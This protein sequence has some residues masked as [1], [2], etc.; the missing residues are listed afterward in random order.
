MAQTPRH[1]EHRPEV[2]AALLRAHPI[3]TLVWSD[4]QGR[5]QAQHLPMCAEG[6]SAAG[7]LVLCARV[8]AEHPLAQVGEQEAM[9]IFQGRQNYVGPAQQAGT[10]RWNHLA[11]HARGRLCVH[12]EPA[13]LQQHLTSVATGP[14]A[15]PHAIWRGCRGLALRVEH[16]LGVWNTATGV[17]PAP[18]TAVSASPPAM[19]QRRQATQPTNRHRSG[20]R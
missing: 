15:S 10:A 13:W 2:L 3:A 18:R 5:L 11:V 6:P 9:A 1:E 19:P 16:I 14:W 8:S 7:K 4:P 12:E 17:D 20:E